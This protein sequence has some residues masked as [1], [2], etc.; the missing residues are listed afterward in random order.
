MSSL[1]WRPRTHRVVGPLKHFSTPHDL[2]WILSSCQE[3][4]QCTHYSLFV[5][6]SNS[7]DTTIFQA[8]ERMPNLNHV[9]VELL[10][11]LLKFVL[12]MIFGFHSTGLRCKLLS[13]F[14][15]VQQL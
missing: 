7:S 12:P 10:Y 6:P 3:A 2:Y 9:L 1:Q 14:Y 8:L 15:L 11:A 5:Q 4:R 13:R